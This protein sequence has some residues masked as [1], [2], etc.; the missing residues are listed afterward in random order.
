MDNYQLYLLSRVR[1]F[2]SFSLGASV[3]P[4]DGDL[5][6]CT[7]C[8]GDSDDGTTFSFHTRL[9]CELILG[10]VGSSFTGSLSSS[11]SFFGD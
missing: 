6:G 9:V 11:N 7:S 8:E 3:G 2:K 4:G 1:I 5:D 10:G